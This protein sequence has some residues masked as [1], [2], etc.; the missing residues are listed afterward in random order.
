MRTLSDDMA[1][2]PRHEITQDP[3]HHLTDGPGRIVKL[4]DQARTTSIAL[5][6]EP[7]RYM[8]VPAG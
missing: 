2:F 5:G 3:G 1:T 8:V 6:A 7:A 4:L